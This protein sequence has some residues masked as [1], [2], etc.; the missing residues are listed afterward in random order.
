MTEGTRVDATYGSGLAWGV[1][2]SF[3][4]YVRQAEGAMEVRGK[5]THGPDGFVFPAVDSSQFDPVSGLGELRFEGEVHFTAH[6]GMLSVT[7]AD[8]RIAIGPTGAVLTVLDPDYL[9][10]RSHRI[11]VARL[12]PVTR[13]VDEVT[14]A[15]VT[16]A[17]T[18][19]GSRLLGDVYPVNTPLDPVSFSLPVAAG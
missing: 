13:A 16:A 4:D 14:W 12:G 1:K 7:V 9:P 19:Q 17:L 6:H 8:P 15:Q 3:R 18:V 11:K 5:A 10:D 2:A